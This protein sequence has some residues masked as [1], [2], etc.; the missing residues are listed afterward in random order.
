MQATRGEATL[1]VFYWS[2]E[3]EHGAI[4][5]EY[6]DLMCPRFHPYPLSK[7]TTQWRPVTDVIDMVGEVLLWDVV[8][9]N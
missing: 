4:R 6:T 7:I 5:T 3:P 9:V 1:A 2:S 8:S